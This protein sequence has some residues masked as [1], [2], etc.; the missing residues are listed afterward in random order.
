MEQLVIIR[1]FKLGAWEIKYIHRN[2]SWKNRTS[3]AQI[4]SRRLW[5]GSHSSQTQDFKLLL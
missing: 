1:F 3:L 2:A 4:S 5:R